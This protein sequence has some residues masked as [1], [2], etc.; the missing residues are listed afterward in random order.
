MKLKECL[1]EDCPYYVCFQTS[2]DHPESIADFFEDCSLGL[3]S[4]RYYKMCPRVV[5]ITKEEK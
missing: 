4:L 5:E 1:K 3:F 2:I